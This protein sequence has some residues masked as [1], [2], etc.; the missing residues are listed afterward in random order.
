M[1][2]MVF[3][4]VDCFE[5]RQ[6]LFDAEASQIPC[7]AFELLLATS[8]ELGSQRLPFRADPLP[9]DVQ[10]VANA[11]KVDPPPSGDGIRVRG[12]SRRCA[13]H[14]EPSQPDSSRAPLH[15]QGLVESPITDKLQDELQDEPFGLPGKGAALAL[16]GGAAV[17][18][19][20]GA[21]AARS[22]PLSPW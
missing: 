1:K 3:L 17:D 19:P 16:R 5:V 21:R 14:P 6:D 8:A 13:S 18:K 4:P 11:P 20:N 7:H 9:G 22:L 15:F 10:L 12:C 2:A